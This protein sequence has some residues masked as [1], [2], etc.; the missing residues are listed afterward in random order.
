MCKKILCLTLSL[1]LLMSMSVTAFAQTD[2]S[3]TISTAE[4][5]LTFAENCRLDTY[6]QGLTVSLE[7][8]IDLTG[9]A[10]SPIPYF[11]GTFLGNNHTVSGISVTDNGSEIGFFRYLSQTA[12]VEK[13]HIGG[14][15]TPGGSSV[16]IGGI[17]GSN[18]G[19]ISGCSFSGTISGRDN[20]GGIAGSNT[21]TGIIEVCATEGDFSGNHF[22]GGIAGS[23]EGVVRDC[24]NNAKVNNDSK[25][26]SVNLSDITL[27]TITGTENA[28]TVTDIGGIAGSNA[29]VIRDCSNHGA[30]GYP[31]MGYNIGGIVGS[32]TGFITECENYGAVSGRKDVGGIA[33]QMEPAVLLQYDTDTFQILEGQLATLG[34]LADKAAANAQN[35][36]N[37]IKS[38]ITA[39]QTHIQN[40]EDALDSLTDVRDP[41]ALLAIVQTVSSSL[42]GIDS[43]IRSLSQAVQDTG[44]Q[45]EKDLLAVADQAKSI[46]ATLSGGEENLGG[47]ITD[48]SDEDTDEDLT[49]KVSVS[50]NYAAITGDWNIGGI[51]GAMALENDLDPEQ[52][53]DVSGSMTFNAAG[54]LRSVILRCASRGSVNA[55]KQ[56]AGGIAGWQSMGLVK[57]CVA[58]SRIT[59]D[60]ANYVGGIAGRSAGTIRSCS[61]KGD[62]TGSSFVG[63][64]AGSGSV[65]TDCRSMTRLFGS[66]RIGS[67]LG[68]ADKTDKEQP[69]A[70]NLYIFDGKDPGGIDG[71]SYSGAAE[72]TDYESFYAD[73]NVPATFD[74][75]TITYRFSPQL[76]QLVYVPAGCLLKELEIPT[77]PS[78]NGQL[79]HWQGLEELLDTPLYWDVTLEAV[80]LGHG[81]TISSQE[82]Q[83][84][85]PLLLLQGDFSAESVLS[86]APMEG[87]AAPEEDFVLLDAAQFSVTHS[88]DL[89]TARYLLPGED[90]DRLQVR[91]LSSDGTWHLAE[92][93]V[94]GSYVVFPVSVQD[95]GFALWRMPQDLT[96]WFVGGGI[97]LLLVAAVT[98]LLIVK[99]KKK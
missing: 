54:K 94:D 68:F 20:I 9:L 65:V 59:A 96:W 27:E 89:T 28:I 42:T 43:S 72:S 14:N 36:T 60:T 88:S 21:V 8:D 22:V 23:N 64:I 24:K 16:N 12:R 39:L 90:A 19:V 70:G 62:L 84:G 80:Y 47:S 10:F 31:Y 37:Q 55:R 76:E 81:Y 61:A 49:G 7:A 45:L 13:L 52:D 73:E 6:S 97:A 86:V 3:L 11:A 83:D 35:N 46:E 56:N 82:A 95:Q 78:Q 92:H 18:E 38:H 53:I 15:I 2:A 17:A 71:V 74:E 99:R 58:N 29:G 44:T 75:V 87:V 4:E 93:T 66:E 1:I 85:K 67:I 40:A 34:S 69:I 57:N 48:V 98:V 41:D 33:G 51:T 26:N 50:M 30:V 63:G 5:F 32:L 79:G 77:I 91:V 25:Q